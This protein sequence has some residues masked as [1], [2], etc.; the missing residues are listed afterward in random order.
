MYQNLNLNRIPEYGI[1]HT[2]SG[3]FYL[4]QKVITMS[5]TLKNLESALAGESMAYTKY[6]YFAKIA[7]EDGFED[8]AKHF[9][10]TASQELKHAWG[11]LELLIGRPSTK[12]CLEKAIE[13][14]TYEFTEMYPQFQAIAESEGNIEAAKEANEQIAESKEHAR[15]FIEILEKAEKRFAALKRVEQRHAEAYQQVWETVK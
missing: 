2:V 4:L 7:R 5:A 15:E 14:E 10:H 1:I 13:G 8:V 9:E 3:I 12:I 11:H 6:M